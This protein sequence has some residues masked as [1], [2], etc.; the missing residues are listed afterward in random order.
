VLTCFG[1]TFAG[2]VAASQLHAVGLPELVATSLG[3]YEALAL[4][5]ARDPDRLT[6]LKTKLAQNRNTF[7]LFDTGRFTRHI[8]RAYKTMLQRYQRGEPPASFA[9]PPCDGTD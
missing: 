3:D 9:V 6:A 7:P 4:Q 8:E 2:R 1:S 5:I